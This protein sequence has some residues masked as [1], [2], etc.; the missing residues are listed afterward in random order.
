MFSLVTSLYKTDKYLDAHTKNLRRFANELKEK[1]ISFEIIAIAN[2]VSAREKQFGKDFSAE[3]WFTFLEVP[4]E[5]VFA[6]FN[7]AFSMAKGDVFGFWNVDD[8]RYSESLVEAEKLFKE[9]AE[10]VYFPFTVKRYF[11]VGPWAVPLIWQRI[12]KQIPEFN[13]QTKKQFLEGMICG[14]HFLFTKS[15]YQQ[16]GPF[17]EQFKIAGDFDWCI[18]AAKITDKF[19][20]AKSLSG[21]FRV[22]GG[23]LSAGANP[24]RSAENNLIYKRYNITGKD[25]PQ[26]QGDFNYRAD[27]ILV[28]GNY[29]D[30]T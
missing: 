11:K 30:I 6:T 27:A 17:D 23:G 2:D 3:S 4:R 29:R 28:G 14:P 20:K 10:L 9:G 1:N 19:V 25:E 13:Q 5:S 12:D 18:R 8:V 21:V 22:D 26:P 7:R 15:L 16:V 24:R